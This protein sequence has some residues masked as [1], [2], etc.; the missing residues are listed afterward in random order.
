MSRSTVHENATDLRDSQSHASA[1]NAR[2]RAVARNHSFAEEQSFR[3]GGPGRFPGAKRS[4]R[5]RGA[6]RLLWRA[7]R[8]RPVGLRELP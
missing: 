1:M 6:G 8:K 2:G 7:K 4:L 5:R 3:P